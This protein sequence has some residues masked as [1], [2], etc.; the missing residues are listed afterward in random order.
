MTEQLGSYFDSLNKIYNFA[1][2]TLVLELPT[3]NHYYDYRSGGPQLIIDRNMRIRT[4]GFSYLG[5]NK[6]TGSDMPTKTTLLK[7][8][9]GSIVLY[10]PYCELIPIQ[11]SKT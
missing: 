4:T 3:K 11:W 10:I 9:N 5:K 1:D 6:N 7:L 2:N 8:A